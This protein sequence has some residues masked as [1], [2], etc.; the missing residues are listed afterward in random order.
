[1]VGLFF[2]CQWGFI[3]GERGVVG[4]DSGHRPV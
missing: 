1:M 3:A 4:G 2:L